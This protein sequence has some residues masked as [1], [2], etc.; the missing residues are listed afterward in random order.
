MI[1]LDVRMPDIGGLELAQIIKQRK[2][3]Q[4]CAHYFSDRLLSGR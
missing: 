1:V 4:S 2:K 3:T